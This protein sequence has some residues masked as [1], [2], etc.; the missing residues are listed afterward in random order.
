VGGAIGGEIEADGDLSV[1]L[2]YLVGSDPAGGRAAK[3]LAGF[4]AELGEVPGTGDAAVL[5]RP[6]GDGGVGVGTDI[7]DGVDPAVVPDQGNA[8]T[9][10]LVG[11]AFSFL[12]L[13]RVGQFSETGRGVVHGVGDGWDSASAIRSDPG[14]GNRQL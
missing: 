2:S 4:E 10:Q 12:K 3:D 9:V 5:H 1:F 11:A 6:E 13:G 8:V 14:G 7:I